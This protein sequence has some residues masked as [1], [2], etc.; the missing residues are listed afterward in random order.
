MIIQIILIITFSWCLGTTCYAQ[1]QQQD[2]T[3]AGCVMRQNYVKKEYDERVKKWTIRLL[4]V[5]NSYKEKHI[6]ES[7][8]LSLKNGLIQEFKS[9]EL[10][11]GREL[12]QVTN[13]CQR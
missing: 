8:Y 5:E 9:D 11:F 10:N 12:D 13:E 3:L 4:E 6:N 2:V 7:E 1:S